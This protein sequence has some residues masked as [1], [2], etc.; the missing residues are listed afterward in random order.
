MSL[1]RYGIG[2][3]VT[4]VIGIR[5]GLVLF[6]ELFTL[7]LATYLTGLG[8]F[9]G[10]IL[11][12]VTVS[13]NNEI[14]VCITALTGVGGKAAC[15][16]G[17]LDRF[18]CIG[19][20]VSE[21][22]GLRK[23]NFSTNG[24]LLT[25][26]K[27]VFGTGR[28]FAFESYRCVTES[29]GFIRNVRLAAMTGIG[30]I[31]AVFTVGS[32]H[33]SLVAMS[34][35]HGL[36]AHVACVTTV[37]G[38]RGISAILAIG[39]DYFLIVA[40]SERS[41]LVG[42]VTI[43]ARGTGVGSVTAVNAIRLYHRR[44]VVMSL[45][46]NNA[47]VLSNLAASRATLAV[48]ESCGSA[49]SISAGNKHL[50]VS[51]GFGLVIHVTFTTVDTSASGITAV[52]TV[53]LG[54]YRLVAMSKSR[55]LLLCYNNVTADG[56]LLALGKT[57]FGAGGCF[58][59]Q[60][61]FVM[62]GAQILIAHVTGVIIISI[63]VTYCGYESLRLESLAAHGAKLADGKTAFR[64]GRSFTL[65]RLFGVS[66]S[67]GGIGNVAVSAYGA[68]IGGIAAVFTVGLG[69]YRV[70]GVVNDGNFL[71]FKENLTANGA[72]LTLGKSAF[73]AGGCFCRQDFFVMLGAKVLTAHVAVVILIDIGV[74][75]SL[76]I[77]GISMRCVMLTGIGLCALGLARRCYGYFTLVP[78]VSIGIKSAVRHT[79]NCTYGVIRTGS[80][81]AATFVNHNAECKLGSG[82]LM[83]LGI[84]LGVK[85]SLSKRVHSG[86]RR[87]VSGGKHGECI[88]LN[89]ESYLLG[90]RAVTKYYRYGK[91]VK[92]RVGWDR[93]AEHMS[94]ASIGRECRHRSSEGSAVRHL[95]YYVAV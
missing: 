54:Y 16:A 64:T 39:S 28:C 56:A 12:I 5:I 94:A 34:E 23:E 57:A 93:N 81:A 32:G 80:S 55:N 71:L 70:I 89:G 9:G 85:Y 61:F 52:F 4:V 83:S 73:G 18:N 10:C 3:Y 8:C 1:L 29:L 25:V 67:L 33:C 22:L 58:C 50:S 82:Y 37:T 2:C 45:D 26:G 47:L 60:D 49:G 14:N 87:L 46:R 53:G 77:N 62:L 31:A 84:V 19:V 76:E 91:I 42:Y 65:Y 74:S 21:N 72:L 27:T 75:E 43:T 15:S 95:H 59:R 68:G 92:S 11:P 69:Y 38:V 30:C 40:V 66:E 36:I 7:G 86:I 24:A 88:F 6:G 78:C 13:V 35:S 63:G 48:G 90:V 20:T 51:K 17:R 79:A 41:T 44:L